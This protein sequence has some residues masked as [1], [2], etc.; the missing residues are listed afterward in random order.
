VI[1]IFDVNILLISDEQVPVNNVKNISLTSSRMILVDDKGVQT[2]FSPGTINT[3]VM[4]N[5]NALAV[6]RMNNESME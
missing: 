6:R 3:M 5:K 2:V 1:K 4:F